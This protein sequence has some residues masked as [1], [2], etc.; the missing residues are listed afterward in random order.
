M[1]MMIKIFVKFDYNEFSK[2]CLLAAE[3]NV[4]QERGKTLRGKQK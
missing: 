1:I 4:H 2:I 3:P